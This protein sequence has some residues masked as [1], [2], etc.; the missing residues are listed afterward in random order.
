MKYFSPKEELLR[1]LSGEDIGYFPRCIPVFTPVVD[2]MRATGAYFPDANYSAQPMAKLALAAHELGN[3]NF[4]M[5]PWASTVEMEALGC[6]VVN[7]EDDIAGYPQFKKRAFDDAYKVSFGSDILGR[8]SF[9]AV[10]E[11]TRI[12]RDTIEKKYNGEIPVVS[13]FQGPFT[14]AGYVIGVNDMFRHVIK[15]VKR[16]EGVLDVVSDLNILYGNRML[17]CGGDVILMSDPAAEGLTG[18]Q[19]RS[20]LLP[21]YRKISRAIKSKKMVHI[22][23]RTAKI[24]AYLAESGFGGFSFDFPGVTLEVLKEKTLGKIRLIGSVPTVT[25]LLEGGKADVI[26]ISLD[27]IKKGTDMLSPSCGLPQYTPLENVKAIPEA[28]EQW[29]RNRR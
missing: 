3:W 4:V 10:F 7:K 12:V 6:E 22:C 19:F 8:G 16:A 2:M 25:H 14:I 11:A 1:T 23:G 13:M 24:A 21:V 15:D 29:N 5:L 26:D 27:M 9:P 20:A 18:E 28:V 17:E